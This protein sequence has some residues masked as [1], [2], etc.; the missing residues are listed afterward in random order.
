MQADEHLALVP[1]VFQPVVVALVGGEEV[2]QNGAHIQHGPAAAG[3][4]LAA[5]GDGMLQFEM[6]AQCV[7][8]A[9]QHALAGCRA[10][11]KIIGNI[12]Q[13]VNIQQD[14]VFG[15]FVFEKGD[16]VTGKFERVQGATSK[17][18]RLGNCSI[19]I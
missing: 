17:R 7:A 12:A 13:A 16:D 4:T 14:N 18:N 15:F 2:H 9:L 5:G 3:Q 1:Q 11:D 8:Q 6:L 10:D 19:K